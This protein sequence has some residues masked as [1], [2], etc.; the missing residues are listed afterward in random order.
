MQ[1][2][3]LTYLKYLPCQVHGFAF[4]IHAFLTTSL[5]ELSQQDQYTCS[6]EGRKKGV[7]RGRWKTCP[8]EA[9]VGQLLETAAHEIVLPA[10]IFKSSN[11]IPHKASPATYSSPSKIFYQ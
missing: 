3:L 6:I 11:M 5:S 1:P 4:N 2:Y 8:N 7:G 9:L 10:N